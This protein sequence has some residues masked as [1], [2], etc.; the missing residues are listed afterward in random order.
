MLVER[1]W[2]HIANCPR[3]LWSLVSWSS[4][5]LTSRKMDENGMVG[6]TVMPAKYPKCLAVTCPFLRMLLTSNHASRIPYVGNVDLWE[7][8]GVSWNEDSV[9]IQDCRDE[10]HY[11]CRRCNYTSLPTHQAA[12]VQ[13]MHGVRICQDYDSPILLR[14][15]APTFLSFQR[16][17]TAVQPLVST[18]QPSASATAS[19]FFWNCVWVRFSGH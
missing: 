16:T 18:D 9:K 17:N 12:I 4:F 13:T 15:S 10:T 7:K 6:Q 14:K 8:S 11:F 2:A 19:G 5:D 1:V 3:G